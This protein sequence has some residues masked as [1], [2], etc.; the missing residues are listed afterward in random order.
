[1]RGLGLIVVQ[2]VISFFLVGL[3]MP[4]VVMTMPLARERGAGPL[5]AIGLIALLFLA[6]RV[7]WPKPARS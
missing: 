1:M 6:L 4:V 3:I 2:I 5:L 7:V